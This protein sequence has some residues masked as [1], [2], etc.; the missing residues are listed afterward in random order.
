[1]TKQERIRE[2]M[3]IIQCNDND[4]GQRY[5]YWDNLSDAEREEYMEEADRFIAYLHS[6]GL[7]AK[8]DRELPKRAWHKDWGGEEGEAGYALALRDMAGAVE[9]IIKGDVK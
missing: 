6:E 1:M 5:G 7:V 2:G 3:A 8:V 9:P 4:S